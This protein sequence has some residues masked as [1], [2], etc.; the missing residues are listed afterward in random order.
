MQLN[1]EVCIE[2]M[3]YVLPPETWT[4]EAIEKKLGPLYE[5]L[6]LPFGRLELMTGIAQRRF[7]S[8]P[9]P[10]SEA[11]AD[12]AR[13]T[14]VRSQFGVGDIDVVIHSAVCRDRLEPATASYVHRRLGM[15]GHTQIF[16]LSNA[17]LGFLN[18]MGVSASMI[19]S[20]HI[21]RALVV[22]GE[23]GRPLVERTIEQLLDPVMT[24]QTIKP[25]FANLT[26]GAGSVAAILCRTSEASSSR[27]RL[28][29]GIV[30]TDTSRNDLCEGDT[31]GGNAL[32]MQTDSEELL[33]VGVAV[34]ERTWSAFK[35]EIGWDATSPDRVITHQVGR[36]HQRRLYEALGINPSKDFST[37]HFL[38]N[39]GSVSLPISLAIAL[40]KGEILAGHKVA[41]MGIGSGLSCMML[42]LEV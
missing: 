22:A 37:Y 42:G 6:N 3:G 23:N 13:E 24:R 7:W 17:C 29:N 12:A 36:A 4:S 2:S 34:A 11:S 35:T 5:R 40:E 28:K 10:P 33:N 9:V 1:G 21:D 26:I 14:I 30:L 27:P 8:T 25:Y 20:G 31:A 39:V 41:L 18:A 16:D 19:I 38:G 32:E 15:E